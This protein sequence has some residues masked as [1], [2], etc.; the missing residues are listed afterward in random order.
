MLNDMVKHSMTGI[1]S[2]ANMDP[3][4]ISHWRVMGGGLSLLCSTLIG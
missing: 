2:T 3:S 1:D 4:T